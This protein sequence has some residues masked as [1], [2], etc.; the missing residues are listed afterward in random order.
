MSVLVAIS[1]LLLVGSSWAQ[2]NPKYSLETATSWVMYSYA[3]YC[4]APQLENWN[5][6]WC[7][8][9]A[10]TSVEP[11]SVT[12]VFTNDSG[13]SYGYAGVTNDFIVI[14]FRGTVP[15][16]LQNWITDLSSAVLVPYKN[17][18]NVQVAL[19]FWTAYS[20]IQPQVLNATQALINQYPSL[21]IVF[22]GHSLGAAL[23]ILAALDAAE[24]F[25]INPSSISAWNFGDPRVGNPDFAT[26]WPTKVSAVSWRSVNQN[27]L[28][29]HLPP[30]LLGFH[31]IA[32]EVWYEDSDDQY[33]ICNGS[34][35]DPSCSDSVIGDSIDDHLTYLGYDQRD[36]IPYNCPHM[37]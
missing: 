7:T 8:Y 25:G 28:V 31:H 9:H 2:Y 17:V 30:K 1:F 21:P 33:E 37:W 11:V 6:Y 29:P 3:A 5:C 34:G 23:S 18:P 20:D 16:D 27:D 4:E 14:S 10:N 22:T 13:D 24:T 36:G 35:E 15:T 32:T 12:Y 26:Y 19:G